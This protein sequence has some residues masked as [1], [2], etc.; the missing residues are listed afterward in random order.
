VARKVDAFFNIPPKHGHRLHEALRH[1]TNYQDQSVLRGDALK[2]VE[3]AHDTAQEAD[4]LDYK[5]YMWAREHAPSIDDTS[6][7]DDVIR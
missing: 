6:P 3:D 7:H 5:V 1:V 4:W 2:A